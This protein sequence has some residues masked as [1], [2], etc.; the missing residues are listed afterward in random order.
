ME[1]QARN[2]ESNKNAV[3]KNIGSTNHC[4]RQRVDKDFY[5]TEPKAVELL[6]ESEHFSHKVWECASGENHIADVLKAH[7]YSVRTSDIVQ[8]T[9]T[10]EEYDFLGME[11]SEWDGDIIT[12]PP[13]SCALEF[14]ERA[15]QSVGIGHKVA[16]FL[17]LLFLEGKTRKEFFERNPPK[18][19]Y[20]ASGRLQC[21][22]GGD[23]LNINGNSAIAYAWFVWEKGFKGEPIIRWIN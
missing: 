6:L 2:I 1:K 16:M 9:P 18:V 20:V 12:N 19:V 13:Y 11:I 7:G 8:R 4:N 22:P 3:F 10:T 23:Y 15:L 14:V 17:R 21:I 5:A